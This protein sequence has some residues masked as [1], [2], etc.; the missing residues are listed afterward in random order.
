MRSIFLLT[1]FFCASTCFAQYSVTI[2]GARKSATNPGVLTISKSDMLAN[3]ALSLV[4]GSGTILSFDMSMVQVHGEY[5]GP[6]KSKGAEMTAEQISWV[7]RSHYG[8]KFFFEVIKVKTNDGTIVMPDTFVI[9][10]Q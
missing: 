5:V 10:I 8:D 1:C 2:V 4:S 6:T 3:H 9:M 7:Q